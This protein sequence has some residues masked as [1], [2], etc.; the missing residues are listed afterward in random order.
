MAEDSGAGCRVLTAAT[1]MTC[2][3][4]SSKRSISDCVPT[5]M[6][7]WVGH[8]GQ[9]RPIKTFCADIAAMTSLA[10]RLASSMRQLS[11]DGTKEYPF[12]ESH[13]NVASRMLVLMRLRSG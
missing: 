3:K 6:R 11:C 13:G 7:T 10:G 2:W 12:F 1:D 9:G 8:T 4:A 5:V